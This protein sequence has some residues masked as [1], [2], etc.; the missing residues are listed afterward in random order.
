[1]ARCAARVRLLKT[2]AARWGGREDCRLASIP[3][4]LSAV[5]HTRCRLLPIVDLLKAM[6]A[7]MDVPM[8][9]ARREQLAAELEDSAVA[10]AA[11]VH[12]GLALAPPASE[13]RGRGPAQ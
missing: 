3:S 7:A 9:M 10:E 6:A 4:V 5:K 12:L 13:A 1:M 11:C 8:G 2:R